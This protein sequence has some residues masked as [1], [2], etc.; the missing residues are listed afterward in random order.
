MGAGQDHPE[1][2]SLLEDQEHI[3]WQARPKG[4]FASGVCTNRSL[5]RWAIAVLLLGAAATLLP[6]LTYGF[7][8][9]REEMML[10]YFC[11]ILAASVLLL[12]AINTG[13][14]NMN[15]FYTLSNHYGYVGRQSLNL[16]GGSISGYGIGLEKELIYYLFQPD[17]V[18]RIESVQRYGKEVLNLHVTN[19][20]DNTGQIY[21]DEFC[22]FRNVPLDPALQ[23]ATDRIAATFAS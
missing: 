22:L 5:R 21:S 15:R 12:A 19:C 2:K 16:I 23:R 13:I 17:T 20:T 14:R 3:L 1:W 4:G 11:V 18:F 10:R 6:T 8:N 9:V 7:D